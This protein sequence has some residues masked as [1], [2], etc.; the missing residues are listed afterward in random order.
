M[1]IVKFVALIIKLHFDLNLEHGQIIKNYLRVKART[2]NQL[3]VE[4]FIM[5][6]HVLNKY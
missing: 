2:K 1:L 6:K 3:K 4:N 5:K